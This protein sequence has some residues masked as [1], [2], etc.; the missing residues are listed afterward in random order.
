MKRLVL[1]F[2]V[3]FGCLYSIEEDRLKSSNFDFD[4]YLKY[5]LEPGNS[6][7]GSNFD[8]D[9][10]SLP[11]LGEPASAEN[12]RQH[13]QQDGLLVLDLGAVR[14]DQIPTSSNANPAAASSAPA[15]DGLENEPQEDDDID[16]SPKSQK[17]TVK[18]KKR[19]VCTDCPFS[20][21]RKSNI[22]RHRRTHTGEKPFSCAVCG[23]PF[24]QKSHLKVHMKNRH[25][26]ELQ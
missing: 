6:V 25:Q 18:V 5:I 12:D 3:V 26:L 9:L 24:G 23:F 14:S 8:F 2:L 21:N 20:T 4:Q 17:K 10:A 19:Y 11:N 7:D 22:E 13:N 1:S 16:W 15:E